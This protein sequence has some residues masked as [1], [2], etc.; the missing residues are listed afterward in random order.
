VSPAESAPLP[1]PDSRTGK[2]VEFDPFALDVLLEVVSIQRELA[3]RYIDIRLVL[4]LTGLRFGELR[5]LRVRISSG[6]PVRG[7]W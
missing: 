2:I 1:H 7:S 3:G 6:C 5:G 4:G